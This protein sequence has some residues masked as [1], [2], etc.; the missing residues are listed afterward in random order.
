MHRNKSTTTMRKMIS[1]DHMLGGQHRLTEV[2]EGGGP[3]YGE[4]PAS[5]SV[6]NSGT[7]AL[8]CCSPKSATTCRHDAPLSQCALSVTP[9]PPGCPPGALAARPGTTA[10]ADAGSHASVA[11]TGP[12][13]SRIA[14]ATDRKSCGSMHAPNVAAC[15]AQPS[16]L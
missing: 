3:A 13:E 12:P 6:R 11:S 15:S 1:T 2:G 4:V 9:S 8:P 7:I 10:L 5:R 16:T 14:A